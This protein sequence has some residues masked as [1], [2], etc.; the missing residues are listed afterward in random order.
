V[1]LIDFGLSKYYKHSNG[2][3]IAWIDKKGMIG[4]ARYASLNAHLGYEQGRRDDLEAIGYVLIYFLKSTLPWMNM[5]DLN[6]E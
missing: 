6:K 5:T 1:Y 4:T 3:H 2:N